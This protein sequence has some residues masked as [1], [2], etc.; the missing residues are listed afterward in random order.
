M[1]SDGDNLSTYWYRFDANGLPSDEENK[2]AW[3]ESYASRCEVGFPVNDVCR[4]PLITLDPIPANLSKM[5]DVAQR[6]LNHHLARD[7]TK[8]GRT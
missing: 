8:R 3:L 5:L 1:T 6:V 2:I 4:C 7:L